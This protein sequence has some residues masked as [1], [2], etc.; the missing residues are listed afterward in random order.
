MSVR[1]QTLNGEMAEILRR[2]AFPSRPGETAK[3]IQRRLYELR[4][5]SSYVGDILSPRQIRSLWEKTWKWVPA[6]IADELR[7]RVAIHE[8]RLERRL[9]EVGTEYSRVWALVH[10]SSDSEFYREAASRPG[11]VV[12]PKGGKG[13]GEG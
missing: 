4:S 11:G 6:V 12:H 5:A 10:A 9:Q 13:E 3:S 1:I 2:L 8:Q 7:R